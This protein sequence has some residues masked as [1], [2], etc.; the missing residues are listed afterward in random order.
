MKR[1]LLCILL[2]APA[3]GETTEPREIP[4]GRV[5]SS[6]LQP[7][8]S[9]TVTGKYRELVDQELILHDCEAPFLL[10]RPDLLK[11]ILDFKAERD[12]LSISGNVVGREGGGIAIE[13]SS[14][15]RAPSDFEVFSG[16]ANRIPRRGPGA[17]RNLHE[18]AKRVL[19]AYKRHEDP[20][21]LPLSRSLFS[22][23][24]ELLESSLQEDGVEAHIASIRELYEGLDDRDFAVQALRRLHAK[25]PK[26]VSI[27]KF[28]GELQCRPYRGR[29][30]T[31][32][33]FKTEEGLVQHSGKWMQPREKHLIES[34]EW[35]R[36]HGEPEIVI[37][38]RTDRD[39]QRLAENG[40][41]DLGMRPS[42]VAAALGF[43]DRV[44]RRSLKGRE[45][46]QWS[47]GSR[48]YYFYSGLLVIVP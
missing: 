20:E 41:V 6:G 8:Q 46:D 38:K 23:S 12:N 28:L 44:E 24:L 21:L 13:A 36:D 43:P 37:R 14:I 19:S 9:V 47:Y 34:L 26:N 33:E 45:F 31:Y 15:A 1:L 16:E 32:E 48:N 40:A 7:G 2:A 5:G 35:F 30:L 11:R 17:G 42:E 27:G 29:W 3:I 39:Y 22:E 10:L 4:A 25:F 18:L